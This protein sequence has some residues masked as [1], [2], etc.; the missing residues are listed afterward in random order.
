MYRNLPAPIHRLF[1]REAGIVQSG[2]IYELDG[3]V[4]TSRPCEG[5]CNQKSQVA[6]TQV[7]SELQRH[8]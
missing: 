4:R 1:R 7:V 8:D 6:G 5:W 3:G 2:L